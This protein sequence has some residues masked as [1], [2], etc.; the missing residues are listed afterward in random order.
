MTS[1]SKSVGL[2]PSATN[3]SRLMRTSSDVLPHA[4]S[5]TA[6]NFR[7]KVVLSSRLSQAVEGRGGIE[8]GWGR[9]EGWRRRGKGEGRVDE[10]VYLVRFCVFCFVFVVV[11]VFYM[12]LRLLKS[13]SWLVGWLMS[14]Q[15]ELFFLKGG[16]A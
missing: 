14:Q 13:R 3:V 6:V 5:P 16:S 15:Q 10:E 8:W 4:P 2:Y 7:V 9:G 11:V 1:V 12:Q